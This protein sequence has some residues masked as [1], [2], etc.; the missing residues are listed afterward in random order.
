[1]DQPCEPDHGGKRRAGLRQPWYPTEE[2]YGLVFVY[3]GPPD[4]QP[5]LPRYDALESIPEGWELYA[6]DTSIPA[7]T[8]CPRFPSAPPTAPK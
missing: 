1:M 4:R 5:A 6:D 3:M 8:P 7:A 2:R